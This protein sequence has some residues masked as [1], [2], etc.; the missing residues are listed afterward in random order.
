MIY[1]ELLANRFGIMP[2]DVY[3]VKGGWSAKAYRVDAGRYN[4]F[5][6][7]YDKSQPSIQ[8][9]VNRI[10][11]YISILGWLSKTQELRGLIAEPIPSLNGDYKVETTDHAFLLFTYVQGDTPGERGLSRSQVAELAKILAR[12]HVFGESIPCDTRGLFE[13]VSL[14]FC[15]NLERYMAEARDQDD[16]LSRLVSPKADMI[17]SAIAETVRLRDTAR[18]NAQSLVLCHTDAHYNNVIQS[19]CLVLVD[20]EDLRLAPAEADLFMYAFNPH[21]PA[22]WHAYSAIRSDFHIDAGLLRFYLIRRRLDDIWYY[23]SRIL[24]DEP[25]EDEV[26][27][28]CGRLRSA[29]SETQRLLSDELT[30]ELGI[31]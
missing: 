9:W 1:G 8:P 19:D 23:V 14:S 22:F 11:A 20:W 10:D 4:Y 13:D 28:I 26:S 2:K 16:P 17:R 5:L 6:K 7:V 18:L 3:E 12:L 27:R 29:F 31:E 25:N 24:F 21:W 30:L 15:D